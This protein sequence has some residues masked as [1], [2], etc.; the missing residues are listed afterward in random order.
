MAAPIIIFLRFMWRFRV[1]LAI[2]FLVILAHIWINDAIRAWNNWHQPQ[3]Y[4]DDR[5]LIRYIPAEQC[6]G[7]SS[8]DRRFNLGQ[9][10]C[11]GG[12][13]FEIPAPDESAR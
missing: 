5:H 7:M 10:S 8:C 12:P 11:P 9:K 3:L 1:L 4:C 6:G 2:A 13:P